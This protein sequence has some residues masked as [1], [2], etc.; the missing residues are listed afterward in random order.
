MWK[1]QRYNCP[2]INKKYT[3]L[4]NCSAESL[5]FDKS[6]HAEITNS[7]Y[8]LKQRLGVCSVKDKKRKKKKEW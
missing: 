4:W 2:S 3:K 1:Q 5:K 7:Y 6:L 8:F